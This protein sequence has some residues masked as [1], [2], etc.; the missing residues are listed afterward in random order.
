[1]KQTFKIAATWGGLATLLMSIFMLIGKATGISPIPEPIPKAIAEYLLPATAPLP[2]I[3][4]SAVV[5][6]FGYGIFWTFVFLRIR[7]PI[8]IWHGLALGFALWLI[9]QLV[10][11]PV[12]GW[13]IFASN[14]SPKVAVAT[15]VLHLIYGF[16]VGCGLERNSNRAQDH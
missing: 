12:L 1:M 13:G 9:M 5:S 15:L 3:M 11:F 10:V 7:N 8:R 4:I 6:H 14:L 2:L 16:V